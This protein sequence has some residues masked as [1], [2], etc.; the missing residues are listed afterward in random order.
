MTTTAKPFAVNLWGSHPD[1]GNDDCHTGDDFDTLDEALAAADNVVKHFGKSYDHSVAY[2]EIDGP[3]FHENRKNLRF[4]PS[5][6]DDSAE[7]SER[8]MQAGMGLGIDAYNDEM[9][10]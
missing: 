7:R 6:D 8:A 3:D 9:G 1:A 10:Y 2:I 5:L 4:K